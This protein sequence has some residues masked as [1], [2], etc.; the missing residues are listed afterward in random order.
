LND[1]LQKIPR[2]RYFWYNGKKILLRGLYEMPGPDWPPVIRFD[3]VAQDWKI[4]R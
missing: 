1:T 2:V 4:S 3:R